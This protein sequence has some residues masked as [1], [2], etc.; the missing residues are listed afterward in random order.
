MSSFN[1]VGLDDID[2]E[3]IAEQKKWLSAPGR[4]PEKLTQL[5]SGIDDS[6]YSFVKRPELWSGSRAF[7]TNIETNN[8]LPN[9]AFESITFISD[10]LRRDYKAKDKDKNAEIIEQLKAFNTDYEKYIHVLK[11]RFLQ[12]A[13]EKTLFDIREHAKDM[14]LPTSHLNDISKYL[15]DVGY[16][17]LITHDRVLDKH[18][19]IT[20]K[21]A[22]LKSNVKNH[23]KKDDANYVEDPAQKKCLHALEQYEILSKRMLDVHYDR[24]KRLSKFE[25]TLAAISNVFVFLGFIT[26]LAAAALAI[27]SIFF[28]PLLPACF[29]LGSISYISY[30]SSLMTVFAMVYQ[31]VRGGRS[32]T[33]EDYKSIRFDLLTAPFYVWGGKM[34]GLCR[35]VM[36]HA[37][38]VLHILRFGWNNVASNLVDGA[39]IVDSVKNTGQ[40][41]NSLRSTLKMTQTTTTTTLAA[42]TSSLVTTSNDDVGS[43]RDKITKLKSEIA[44]A[45]TQEANLDSTLNNRD[46]VYVFSKGNGAD[47]TFDHAK[48]FHAHILTWNSTMFSRHTNDPD[49][50]VIRGAVKDYEK[51][52]VNATLSDRIIKLN[53]IHNECATYLINH[54]GEKKH[55]PLVHKLISNLEKEITIL[56]QAAKVSTNFEDTPVLIDT[57]VRKP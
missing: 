49:L 18:K 41:V 47:L 24:A 26:G 5:I 32:P 44:T 46:Y 19:E 28:P 56:T 10:T 22:T 9:S 20:N 13:L 6:A 37:R 30:G 57:K 21:C 15:N 7:E 23:F 40:L 34:V 8:D 53:E 2:K 43:I 54:Q 48:S 4:M 55:Q 39:Y 3:L 27:G 16:L 50:S 14:S 36:N 12:K 25:M 42:L 38:N 35:H 11:Q 45:N 29:L 51:L 33:M 52:D 1:L 31:G 17:N